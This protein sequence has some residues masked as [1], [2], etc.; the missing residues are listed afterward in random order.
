MR[1]SCAGP[2]SWKRSIVIG[3][4]KRIAYSCSDLEGFETDIIKFQQNLFEKGY[5]RN[6]VNKCMIDLNRIKRERFHDEKPNNQ[7]KKHFSDRKKIV[8]KF[9]FHSPDIHNL[10]IKL[11]WQLTKILPEINFHFI[12]TSFK[13]DHLFAKKQSIMLL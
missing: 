8:G 10:V 12:I 1:F 3:A 6:F 11:K 9:P 2:N 13:M 5:P 7:N 4:Y